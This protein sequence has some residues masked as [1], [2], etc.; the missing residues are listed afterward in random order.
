M[1][2]L[3]DEAAAGK[4]VRERGTFPLRAMRLAEKAHRGTRRKA[5]EGADRPD[6]FLH[7]TEVAWRLQ[8]A[9]LSEQVVAAGFLHDLIEDCY[10]DQTSLVSE[11]GDEYVAE[12]VNWV[13]EPEKGHKE[14][15]FWVAFCGLCWKK[16][17]IKKIAA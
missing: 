11:F 3:L 5:P 1:S 6:Y 10:Y 14:K 9:G 16:K 7:L 4:P 12:L 17:A 2:K 8:A 13:S 15:H